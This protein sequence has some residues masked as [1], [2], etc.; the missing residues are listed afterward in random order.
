[1]TLDLCFVMMDRHLL[2]RSKLER[3]WETSFESAKVANSPAATGDWMGHFDTRYW[4]AG[5]WRVVGTN[6]VRVEE[7]FEAVDS[8]ACRRCKRGLR[9]R[10]FQSLRRPFS[11]S[12]FFG[13]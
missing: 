8:H 11:A 4:L 3:Y 2:T 1:M 7:E 10:R 5:H 12:D 9:A 13:Y 6:F